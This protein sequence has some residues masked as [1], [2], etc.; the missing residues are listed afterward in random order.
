[1][2]IR[3]PVPWPGGARV[4]VC[5]SYDMD[6]ESLLHLY[7][8]D[9]AHQKVATSSAL[10]YGPLVA[11][12]RLIDMWAKYDIKQTVFIPGWCVETYPDAVRALHA[13]GHEIGHHGYLHEKPNLLSAA[14][15]E[16]V[17][18][19]GIEA[20]ANIT[21]K[22]PVG[23]RAPSYA[24][25]ERTLD[26]LLKY[27]FRYDASLLGDEV[28]YVL[29]SDKGSLVELPADMSLDDWPQYVSMKEFG[30]QMPI[31]APA[32]AMEV[33]R[34]DFDA[35]WLYGGLWIAV[36]HPFVSGR[37]SRAHATMELIDY[38]KAKGDVWFAP[39]SQI[40][41]HVQ[42]LIDRGE[43]TPRVERLPHWAPP[44]TPAVPRAAE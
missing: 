13:A 22:P 30:F 4:A 17:L 26:L 9:T 40:A 28:P 3:N 16:R 18:Q 1:M 19:K 10:R 5:F 12:P 37:L 14:E 34:A 25:S 44:L 21:G 20:I 41:A 8:G 36:W 42:G 35:A 24:F 27:G 43:W 6:A 23:Y 31:Q 38:M 32:R 33:F 2:L 39:L 11:I 7:H 15:E 29:Q